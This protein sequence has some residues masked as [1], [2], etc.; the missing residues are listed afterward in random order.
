[1]NETELMNTIRLALSRNGIV[2]FR[3]NVGK[4]RTA[5]G[6]MFDTG[7]PAGFSD[8]MA[9]KDG[10]VYFLEV[11]IRP[12]KPT[13][14]QLDFL[15]QMRNRGCKCGVVYSVEDAIKLLEE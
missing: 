11:K 6:R 14:K 3:A 10:R 1:M 2:T 8:L 7:L 12:N 15:E 4:V 13:G 5:D 9:I